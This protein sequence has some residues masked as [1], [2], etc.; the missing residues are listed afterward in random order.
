MAESS[1]GIDRKRMDLYEGKLVGKPACRHFRSHSDREVA[2]RVRKRAGAPFSSHLLFLKG[3]AFRSRS[4]W[5]GVPLTARVIT[6]CNP[7]SNGD[8][9]LH[10][11]YFLRDQEAGLTFTARVITR[12]NLK[13]N[14]YPALHPPRPGTNRS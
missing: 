7:K 14:G 11:P 1:S 13:S 10:P 3:R 6:R 2:F 5:R 9:A 12:C 4:A 8:P